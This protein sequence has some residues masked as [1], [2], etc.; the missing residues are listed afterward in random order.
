MRFPLLFVLASVFFCSRALA[1]WPSELICGGRVAH[2]Q[3]SGAQGWDVIL[4]WNLQ[5]TPGTRIFLR[6]S[7]D[8]APIKGSTHAY[9][10]PDALKVDFLALDEQGKEICRAPVTV[11]AIYPTEQFHS[12]PPKSSGGH[13]D[14]ARVGIRLSERLIIGSVVTGKGKVSKVNA[15]M[16]IALYRGVDGQFVPDREVA[17]EAV[18]RVHENEAVEPEIAE[19]SIQLPSVDLLDPPNKSME[20]TATAVTHP[21]DAGCAPAVAVAHH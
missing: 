13:Q 15:R 2:P 7:P 8:G 12:I 16:S 3:D 10:R 11:E 20:P 21:A 19:V 18:L 1:A 6:G 5:S 17:F 9:L 14:V 4:V